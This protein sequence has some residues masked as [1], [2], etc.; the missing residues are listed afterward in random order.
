MELAFYSTSHFQERHHSYNVLLR[1]IR[2]GIP[3]NTLP[4][5]QTTHPNLL[6]QHAV[7]VDIEAHAYVIQEATYCEKLPLVSD[8]PL[9][10]LVLNL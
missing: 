7:P 4:I 10:Y 6:V 5:G 8:L 9:A 2:E 3:S 1:Q